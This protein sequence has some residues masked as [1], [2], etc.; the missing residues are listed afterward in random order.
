MHQESDAVL[1]AAATMIS[2]RVDVEMVNDDED[3]LGILRRRSKRTDDSAQTIMGIDHA[4]SSLLTIVRDSKQESPSDTIDA[5]LSHCKDVRNR[6][7]SRQVSLHQAPFT[8][9]LQYNSDR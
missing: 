5:I 2:S 3:P 6:V 7:L 1:G 9:G 8:G 4:R